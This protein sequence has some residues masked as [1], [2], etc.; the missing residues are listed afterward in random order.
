MPKSR[1]AVAKDHAGDAKASTKGK[2][3]VDA[4]TITGLEDLAI[5]N[6]SIKQLETLQTTLKAEVNDQMLDRFVDDG[7]ASGKKPANFKGTDTNA[8]AS[9]QLRKRS[10]R[11]VLTAA[12]TDLLDELGISYDESDD[13]FFYINKKYADDDKLLTK[14][15]KA[16]DKVAGIP[17]DFI[18][19]TPTKYVTTDESI[20]DLFKIKKLKPAQAR[21]AL[22]VVATLATRIKYEGDHDELMEKLAEL[23][24]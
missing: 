12:D 11:S 2:K 16:L 14:V 20:N 7:I 18:E 21:S 9:L 15:S 22:Q 17:T 8:S 4:V 3:A 13:S 6:A 24:D 10:A 23:I 1:F 19:A 5:V